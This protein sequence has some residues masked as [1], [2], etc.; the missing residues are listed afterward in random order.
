LNFPQESKSKQRTNKEFILYR[1][2]RYSTAKPGEANLMGNEETLVEVSTIHRKTP[3]AS[4]YVM[5]LLVF[6]KIACCVVVLL[7]LF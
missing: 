4:L 3:I 1:S 5:N 6:D 2:I 7:R